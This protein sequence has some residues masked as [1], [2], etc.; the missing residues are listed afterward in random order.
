MAITRIAVKNQRYK[1]CTTNNHA[2]FIGYIGF[3]LKGDF[4]RPCEARRVGE[5]DVELRGVHLLRRWVDFAGE[6][7][8]GK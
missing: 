6:D 2:H 7:A 4:K 1:T 8:F 5:I 3:S